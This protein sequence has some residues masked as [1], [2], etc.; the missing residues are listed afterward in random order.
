MIFLLKV[1][2]LICKI[3]ENNKEKEEAQT[4]ISIEKVIYFDKANTNN[5]RYEFFYYFNKDFYDK[6]QDIFLN[7]F[8]G[9]FDLKNIHDSYYLAFFKNLENTVYNDSYNEYLERYNPEEKFNLE[10]NFIKNYELYHKRFLHLEKKLN[11]KSYENIINSAPIIQN[12]LK[13]DIK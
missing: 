2:Q 6:I 13:I 10:N 9:Y 4:N 3:T 11:L 1:I 7:V 8:G 5:T 12:E